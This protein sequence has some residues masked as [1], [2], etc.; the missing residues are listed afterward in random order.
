MQVAFSITFILSYSFIH[1]FSIALTI[2][3][4]KPIQYLIQE[5]KEVQH[6]TQLIHSLAMF[7]YLLRYSDLFNEIFKSFHS[8]RQAAP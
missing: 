3:K 8:C 4:E 1:L 5:L 2:K 7:I 6:T